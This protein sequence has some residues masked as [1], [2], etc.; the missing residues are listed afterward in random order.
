VLLQN[1]LNIL[2]QIANEMGLQKIFFFFYFSWNPTVKFQDSTM[3]MLYCFL[4]MFLVHLAL[5]GLDTNGGTIRL[6]YLMLLVVQ[7]R[8]NFPTVYGT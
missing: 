4:Q 6:T 1:L 3:I 5:S 2:V 8:K 7:P